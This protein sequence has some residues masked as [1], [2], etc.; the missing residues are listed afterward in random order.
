MKVWRWCAQSTFVTALS[1]VQ[2]FSEWLPYFQSGE[3]FASIPRKLMMSAETARNSELGTVMW[4]NTCSLIQSGHQAS[5]IE[6]VDNAIHWIHVNL[7]FYFLFCCSPPYWKRQ[8][9]KSDAECLSGSSCLLW[10]TQDEFLLEALSRYPLHR[11]EKF[12]CFIIV[13]L[14]FHCSEHRIYHL[15]IA[16]NFNWVPKM[17]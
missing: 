17:W 7:L 4:F 14:Q 15:A 8:Y 11:T 9:S 6:K 5:V 13:T 2:Y 12:L 1:A 3:L 10:K 16:I